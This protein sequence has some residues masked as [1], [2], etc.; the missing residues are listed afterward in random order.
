MQ[1]LFFITLFLALSVADPQVTVT[2]VNNVDPGVYTEFTYSASPTGSPDIITI[3]GA[4]LNASN[5]ANANVEAAAFSIQSPTYAGSLGF[6]FGFFAAEGEYNVTQHSASYSASL[7]ELVA[8]FFTLFIY[9]DHNGQPG[10]QYVLG[11]N[12]DC[13]DS[14]TGDDC[15]E[16]LYNMQLSSLTWNAISVSPMVCPAG[17][18]ASCKVYVFT[19]ADTN[20]I[21][22]FT[23][24][25]ASQPVYIDSY[26]VTP[27]YAKLDITI[28]FPW[29]N[30]IY[31]NLPTGAQ[32]GLLGGIGGKTASVS[33]TLSKV[34]SG[35]PGIIFTSQ[36]HIGAFAWDTTAEVT[37]SKK[38]TTSSTVYFDTIYGQNIT[39]YQC[40]LGV[41][42]AV[43]TLLKTAVDV[44]EALGWE[45]AFLFFSWDDVEP[46]TVVWD[47][48]VGLSVPLTDPT[49]PPTGSAGVREPV[50]WGMVFAVVVA[51]M[52]RWM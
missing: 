18:S 17:Y 12:I 26:L 19:L 39:S 48:T 13:A 46:S 14:A 47:P 34:S 29:G 38:R 43:V 27:D 16:L 49:I 35:N 33:A 23:F 5:P 36:G 40:P 51:Y 50:V 41:C 3:K 44:W 11:D 30:A 10:F 37:T 22:T 24:K 9:Y 15:I 52:C 31:A 7:V 2:A 28:N 42:D 21:A 25:L 45:V 1:Y 20:N 4:Y 32:L 6:Y 8:N